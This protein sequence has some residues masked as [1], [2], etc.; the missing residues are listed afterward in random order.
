[1][2]G[3]SG[4]SYDYGWRIYNSR[5]GRFLSVDPITKQYPEL[6][7][8]QFASNTPIQAVDL[9]GLEAKIVIWGDV[10]GKVQIIKTMSWNE[11]MKEKVGCL[12][13]GTMHVYYDKR[14]NKATKVWYE[15]EGFV[16]WWKR[17]GEEEHKEREREANKDSRPP[18]EPDFFDKWIIRNTD[19]NEVKKL[20][21]AFGD[22]AGGQNSN[23]VKD[24]ERPEGSTPSQPTGDPFKPGGKCIGLRC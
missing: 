6:T 14:T 17:K 9:D 24:T 7:P 22:N 13:H 8:Y 1:M 5:I 20:G 4:T 12:G 18:T 15:G 21:D 11:V 23:A 10:N 16:N 2:Y 3:S 19:Q